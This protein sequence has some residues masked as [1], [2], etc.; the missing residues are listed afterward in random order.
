[1]PSESDCLSC[2][3]NVTGVALVEHEVQHSH[4]GSHVA[5]TID[6][7]VADR[8]FRPTDPL[9]DRGFRHKVRLWDLASGQPADGSERQGDR[10][11]WR[12]VRMRAQEVEMQCV[13]HARYL[14]GRWLIVETDLTIA[15]RRL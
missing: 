4:D 10:R 11:R 3:V 8:A 6:T 13:V 14:T 5:R 9:R 1:L 2:E 15:A 7:S 12:Q